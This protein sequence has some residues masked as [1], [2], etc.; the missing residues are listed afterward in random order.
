MTANLKG[1][2]TEKP[3][4]KW[5]S[6]VEELY[7]ERSQRARELRGQ[8]KRIIGY[9]CCYTPVEI[10]TA[11]DMVP[12]RITGSVKEPITLADAYLETIM[13]PYIRSSLDMALKGKYDFLDGLVVPHSCDTVQ[14]IYDIWRHYIKLPYTHY[15]NVPHMLQPSSFEFFLHE[16]EGFQQ[17]LEAF[18]GRRLSPGALLQAIRSHNQNRAL[19]RE[20]YG[21]RK[22]EP[23]AISGT[24]TTKAMVCGASLPVLEYNDL[25]KGVIREL[26]EERAPETSNSLPRLLVYGSEIDDA[27]FIQL[28]E[29][30]GSHVVMDD[31]CLGTRHSWYQV[32]SGQSPLADIARAYLEKTRCPRC[33]RPRTGSHAED[34]ESRFGYLRDYAVEFK[35]KGV[36]LYIIRFCD[37]F[38]LE[39]PEI[40]DYLQNAGFPTL[41]LEDDYSVA[42]IGQLRTRV[43]A[44]LE[45]I[46]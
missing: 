16:L 12:F 36:V 26:R 14:R 33:Y 2:T 6:A 23:P 18:A 46:A 25:L 32:E 1:A 44:F 17:S 24:L 13:C 22:G 10:I 5:L 3:A 43:Q 19:V 40:R 29:E 11:L 41:H 31:L 37:T 38:E 34:L 39:A 4:G 27:T 8:G 28:V 9:F 42:T 21:L 15:I 7:Q 35:V 45:M 20:L 30:C